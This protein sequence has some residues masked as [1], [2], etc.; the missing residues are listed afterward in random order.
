[1][2]L[3][4]FL[5]ALPFLG[6]GAGGLRSP[7]L[8]SAASLLLWALALRAPLRPE[9]IPAAWLWP[10]W[11]AWACLSALLSPEPLIGLSGLSRLAAPVVFFA[12]CASSWTEAQRGPW[13]LS[14][15]AAG[16]FFGAAALLIERPGH[17]WTGLLFPYHNYTAALVAASA[18]AATAALAAGRFP[19]PGRAALALLL[20][21]DL[22]LLWVSNS[23]GA[24]AALAAAAAFSLWRRGRSRALLALFLSLAAGAAFLP[25]GRLAALL[26]LDNPGAQMRPA[27]WK[28]SLQVAADHP[29]LGA[30]PGRFDRGYLRHNFPVPPEQRP[31]RYGLRSAHAHSEALQIAAETGWAGFALFLLAWLAALRRALPRREEGWERDAALAAL[32]CLSAH[33]LVD[34]ILALPA[35][36]LLYASA[37]AASL[38]RAGQ[39]APH[40]GGSHSVLQRAACALGLALAAW[41][42]WPSWA[43]GTYGAMALARADE[44]GPRSAARAL[45]VAPEDSGLWDLL[46]RTQ[47]RKSPP[48]PEGALR[49]LTRASALNPTDASSFLMR[50]ELLRTVGRWEEVLALAFKAGELEPESPQA[51]LQKAEALSRLGRGPQARAELDALE[52]LRA[53][54]PVPASS[55]REALILHFDAERYEAVERLLGGAEGR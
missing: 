25:P 50:A 38:P 37:L 42:W 52:A 41:A 19:A 12:L 17:P 51:R 3:A 16:P 10:A 14:L 44:E 36:G 31:T 18:A 24:L 40:P 23:R 30:G 5:A 22:A 54:G 49:S 39:E 32:L 7:W 46:A 29:I 45:A 20:G 53:K 4:W 55:P 2:D 15:C 48:D 47:L 35:L 28:V 26:K 33:S 9:R 13:A 27:L 1:M 8:W 34:N 43:V 21:A 11:L 6:L